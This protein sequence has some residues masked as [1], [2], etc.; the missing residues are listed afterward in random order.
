[1]TGRPNMKTLLILS[2]VAVQS[3]TV[4][5]DGGCVACKE[6]APVCNTTYTPPGPVPEACNTVH[7]DLCRKYGDYKL[8]CY[9]GD[10]FHS[11]SFDCTVSCISSTISIPSL[12]TLFLTSAVLT[13]FMKSV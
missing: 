10:E 12:T 5:S 6:G 1:M 8:S 13:L 11:S 7:L 9:Y 3:L 2:L 4:L